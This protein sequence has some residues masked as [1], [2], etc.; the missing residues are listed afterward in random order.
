MFVT[1]IKNGIT[2]HVNVNIKIIVSGKE[3]IVRIL[4]RVF[5]KIVNI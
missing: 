2:K 4:A 1:R 3:I 5:V